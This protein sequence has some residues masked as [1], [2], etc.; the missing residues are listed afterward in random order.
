[1]AVYR[2]DKKEAYYYLKPL[3]STNR[4][5]DALFYLGR[6]SYK[7]GEFD[8]ARDYY[9]KAV[10]LDSVKKRYYIYELGNLESF[11]GN[12]D[13]A[14]VYY[15][16]LIDNN[17]G[18]KLK[19][20]SLFRLGLLE[21]RLGNYAVAQKYFDRIDDH[22]YKYLGILQKVF[23]EMH[24][25]NYKAAQTL[26]ETIGDEWNISEAVRRQYFQTKL[27][28][29][30]K[31]GNLDNTQKETY[32]AKQY[33]NY[34]ESKTIEHISRHFEGCDAK[35]IYNFA[36]ETIKDGGPNDFDSCDTYFIKTEFPEYPLV[37][38]TTYKNTK[39][40]ITMFQMENT[41]VNNIRYEEKAKT[42]SLS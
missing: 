32:Y 34:D 16:Y 40:I 11:V 22:S 9:L 26:F 31:Q 5:D 19:N 20:K 10:S 1:M 42:K 2:N 21:K 39:N 23:I 15:N 3:L 6:L 18:S 33:L 13:E 35:E 37:E 4:K 41:A 7:N 29:D 25:D 27:A 12:Y 17:L 14:R 36:I 28:L 24:N 38:V 30:C 8:E